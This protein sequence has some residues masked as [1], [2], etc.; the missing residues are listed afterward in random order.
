MGSGPTSLALLEG[1]WVLER[2]ILHADGQ[3]DRFEGETTFTRTGP[4]LLQDESGWLFPS[5]GAAPLRAT[6]RYVWSREGDRIDIAF[7]DMRPF[8]SFTAGAEAP[9]ATYLCPPDRYA[10]AYDFSALPV[11]K[12]VWTVEGPRKAYVMTN[13]FHRGA[14]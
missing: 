8:H 13:S 7:A 9:E 3:E 14:A 2:R 1:A 10:V 5:R 11:W 6:R 12:S 4:R